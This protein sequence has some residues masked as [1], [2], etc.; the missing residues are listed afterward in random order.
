MVCGLGFGLR[1]PIQNPVSEEWRLEAQGAIVEVCGPVGHST[2]LRNK[3]RAPT[4]AFQ[5]RKSEGRITSAI[6]YDYD[7]DY[8]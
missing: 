7:Y 1:H 6:K 8:E 4:G 3:F 2:L 5:L